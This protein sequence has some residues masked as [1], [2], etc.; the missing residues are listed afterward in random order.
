MSTHN[1]CFLCFVC[2]FCDL[3]VQSTT[4]VM[5]RLSVNLTALFLGRLRLK[6]KKINVSFPETLPTQLFFGP[7]LNFVWT[8][9]NFSSIFRVFW[10]IFMLFL[11]KNNLSKKTLFCLPTDPKKYWDILETRHF[12]LAWLVNQYLAHILSPV[13]D[14]CPA[15]ISSSWRMAIEMISWPISTKECFVGPDDQTRLN[16]RRTCRTGENYPFI[17]IKYRNDPKF[18]DR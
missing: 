2:S 11:Y 10:M 5:S 8:S 15:W 6:A 3:T 16:T 12:F 18:S 13:T 1:T 14:N 9:E 17:I 7:T 4:M